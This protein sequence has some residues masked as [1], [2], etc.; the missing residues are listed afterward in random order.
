[1]LSLG[2]RLFTRW[3]PTGGQERCQA[4]YL[5]LV[6]I[7]CRRILWTEEP[8]GLLSIGL[9]RVRHEWHDLA[10]T[11]AN[12]GTGVCV[13]VRVRVCARWRSRQNMISRETHTTIKNKDLKHLR[14]RELGWWG[15]TGTL[16]KKGVWKPVR[17]SLR[18]GGS[19]CGT[20]TSKN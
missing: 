19:V 1:M 7:Q 5:D 6:G 15:Q 4:R 12:V 20:N 2:C 10:A 8:G 16:R 13:C 3:G 17:H 9:H 18:D 11:A 14:A